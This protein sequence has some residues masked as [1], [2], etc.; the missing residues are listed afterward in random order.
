LYAAH[1]VHC[2][3]QVQWGT[4]LPET[5]ALLVRRWMSA[6]HSDRDRITRLRR[7]CIVLLNFTVMYG[8][9]WNQLCLFATW[10]RHS[11]YI[12][13]L[14]KSLGSSLSLGSVFFYFQKHSTIDSTLNILFSR[15]TSHKLWQPQEEGDGTRN[16]NSLTLFGLISTT[17]VQL[18]LTCCLASLQLD[19]E[20]TV[21][22]Q[23]NSY[24]KL[25]ASP[26]VT[27]LLSS[28]LNVC[29]TK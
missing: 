13:K 25:S 19:V 5:G 8:K 20:G 14:L 11:L 6:C 21:C 23:R 17:R 9:A 4:R 26:G 29:D 28:L 3:L 24:L 15:K 16:K 27:E 7:C 18:Q 2:M 22:S 1:G 10:Q 12:T